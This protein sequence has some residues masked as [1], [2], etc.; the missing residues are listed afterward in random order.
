MILLITCIIFLFSC[1]TNNGEVQNDTISADINTQPVVT[2]TQT[3]SKIEAVNLGGKE[4]VILDRQVE[5]L[6]TY[7]L[8][9]F[10]A[11]EENGNII[12]DVVYQR[13]L[14]VEEK[15]NIKI[16][17]VDK[18]YAS[19]KNEII[20]MCNSGEDIYATVATSLINCFSLALGGYLQDI[21]SIPYIDLNQPWWMGSMLSDTSIADKNYFAS[22]DMNMAS[23]NTCGAVYFNKKLQQDYILENPYT[24]VKD[25]NW[26][27]DKFAEMSKGIT[28][29]INGDGIFGLDDKYGFSCNSFVWQPLF[30]GTDSLMIKKDASEL[31]YF[32][33][34][35]ERTYNVVLKI[36]NFLNNKETTITVNQI[37]GVTDFGGAASKIFVEGRA[38][39]WIELIYGTNQLRDMEDD[40]GI[41]PTPK[42]DETQRDYTTYLHPNHSSAMGIPITNNGTPNTGMI[43]EDMAYFSNVLIRPA[44]YDVTLK[45]KYARDAESAEMLDIIYKNIKID[46][47]IIMREDGIDIDQLMRDACNVN[48]TN[49]VAKF[50]ANADKY[51][52]IIEKAVEA[53]K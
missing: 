24:L 32:N 30:Y 21:K 11:V 35:D 48:N 51:N 46:L 33:P 28:E 7:S 39:F 50:E 8:A 53:F 16:V 17:P 2:E 27:M 52:S 41:I 12:N 42:Y 15:F 31:P 26:T 44:F 10:T 14:L 49:V 40:Y 9:Q 22:G 29:D 38:L 20:K 34:L 37:K 47:A 3:G 25:N 19:G 23:F 4:F 13:N 18:Y 6:Y 5:G 43:L 36:I 1:S 45:T